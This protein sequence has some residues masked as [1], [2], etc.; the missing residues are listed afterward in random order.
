MLEHREASRGS[1]VGVSER[2][3]RRAYPL[4]YGM[5]VID[6]HDQMLGT[7]LLVR[8]GHFVIRQELGIN[9]LVA[10]PTVAVSGV[11]GSMVFLNLTPAEID[12]Y[13]KVLERRERTSNG[14]SLKPRVATLPRLGEALG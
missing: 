6:A 9:Q 3:G 1:R 7:V 4:Q 14:T 12:L 10:L 5:H 13:G 11:I 2:R 8:K